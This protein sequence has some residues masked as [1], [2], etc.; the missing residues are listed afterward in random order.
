PYWS[1]KEEGAWSVPK[2]EIGEE[3]DTLEAA[4]RE[5]EEEIGYHPVGKFIDLGSTRQK[6][7]KVV[8]A[9]AVEDDLPRGHEISSNTFDLEWPPNTG[10]RQTFPE[11]DR[12]RFFSL[13]E[14]RSKINP[15]QVLFIDRLEEQL[16]R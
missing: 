8:Y 7:G 14:A 13:D 12:A 4:V 9:W 1:N 2:G 3:E 6:G 11:I 15:A 10:R 16:N 5:F